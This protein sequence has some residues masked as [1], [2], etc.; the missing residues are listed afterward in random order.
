MDNALYTLAGFG[1]LLGVWWWAGSQRAIDVTRRI[2]FRVLVVLAIVAL[3]IEVATW[4][5]TPQLAWLDPG[6]LLATAVGSILRS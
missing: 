4:V 3:V 2:A 1:F 5:F 6:A